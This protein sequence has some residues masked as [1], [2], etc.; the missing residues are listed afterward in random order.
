MSKCSSCCPPFF[1]SPLTL[2]CWLTWPQRQ[3]RMD[4]WHSSVCL[5]RHLLVNYSTARKI[6]CSL[7]PEMRM[8]WLNAEVS[9]N[10]RLFLFKQQCENITRAFSKSVCLCKSVVYSEIS[11]Q[12]RMKTNAK[13]QALASYSCTWD[14]INI[15]MCEW[16]I[17]MPKKK[18]KNFSLVTWH[19]NC[20]LIYN[21][22]P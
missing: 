20:F 14:V 17:T 4:Q 16:P 6:T 5:Q 11:S 22:M 3:R 8:P 13:L 2:S 12:N 19:Q 15:H 18:K 7:L 1:P 21:Y 10:V 9:K